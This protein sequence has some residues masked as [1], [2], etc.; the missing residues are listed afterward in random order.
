MKKEEYYIELLKFHAKDIL[1]SEGMNK[2]KYFIQHG[3]VTVYEHSVNVA[4]ECIK[5]VE[6]LYIPVDIKAL[7]RG[8][9]LHDYFLYDWHVP[10]KSH[11]WHGFI[12]AKIALKNANRDFKL[13]EIEKD[14]I[15]CHMFPLNIRLP[16]YRESVILEIADKICAT[17]ETI[18]PY[19]SLINIHEKYI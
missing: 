7:I 16:K 17:K 10:D 6:K 3:N 14:M 2:E 11:K 4:I 15:R 1:I 8:A 19:A 18:E 12:H 5:I 9:L 13:S